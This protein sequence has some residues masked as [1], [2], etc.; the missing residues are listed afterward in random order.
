MSEGGEALR[1]ACLGAGYF[2]QF[3]YEAWR[4]IE[5]VRLVG[6]CDQDRDK[7]RAMGLSAFGDLDCMLK[8]SKPD[9]LDIITPPVTHLSA[10]KSAI[11]HGVKAIIC[12]KPFCSSLEEA[13]E[14]VALA[15][16][17]GVTV[18]IHENFRFQPWYRTIKQA[19][20]ENLIGDVLQM[21]FRL[22]TGD[23]QGPRAYLDRQPYFQTM[24]KLLIHETGVHWVDT[25]RFLLG[26]P[27]AVYADLRRYNPVIKGEDSGYF[28]L[29]YAN[30]VRALFDGNRLLDHAAENCRTTLGE[31]VVEGTGGTL[32]LFGDGSVNLR[33]FGD[34]KDTVLLA[35][36]D[37][38]GFGG[39]CVYTL[40]LHVVDGLVNG[41]PLENEAKDYL[42]VISV[43]QAIYQSDSLGQKIREFDDA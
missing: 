27:K 18:V 5:R 14:A 31:A 13:K 3:H 7:A 22:R 36:Q 17:A 38:D 4:K 21:T 9:L 8:M 23:G 19:M 1:V 28:I 35:A 15:E 42:K 26:E 32:S 34:L 16:E 37:W 12:Q 39:D 41:K 40:I 11:E 30:G 6:A 10:V 43:E 25:F 2:A 29:D 24:P 33:R 20:D